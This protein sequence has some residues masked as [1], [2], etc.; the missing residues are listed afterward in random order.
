MGNGEPAP[1]EV[2]P[3][4]RRLPSW[5]QGLLLAIAGAV[6]GFGGCLA[7]LNDTESLMGAMG[8]IV[9]VGGVIA[10]P[11]GGIWFLIG[12]IKAIVAAAR[13]SE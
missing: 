5:A 12:V 3:S 11:I 2:Q 6:L 13:S 10:V 1:S 7:W 8:A 9:F 4:T